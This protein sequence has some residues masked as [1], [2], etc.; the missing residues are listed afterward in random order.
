MLKKTTVFI[1][2]VA[3]LLPLLASCASL[4]TYVMYTGGERGTYYNLGRS[5]A[6]IFTENEDTSGKVD[7]SKFRANIKVLS[8]SGYRQNVEALSTGEAHLAIVRNDIAYF[9]QNGTGC[10]SEAVKGFS[11]IAY[12]YSEAVHIVARDNITSLAEL[13]DLRVAVG[14]KGSANEIIFGQILDACGAGDCEKV[15]MSLSASVEAYKN[16]EIDA[17]FT[18]TGLPSAT[19]K[20]LADTHKFALLSIEDSVIES[21]CE[22]YP[23]FSP[24]KVSKKNYSVLKEDMKTVCLYA[25]LLASDTLEKD[26]VYNMTKRIAE[27]TFLMYHDK[28]EELSPA[29][30][31]EDCCIV[32]HGGAEKYYKEYKKKQEKVTTE[33][34]TTA[35]P[36]ETGEPAGETTKAE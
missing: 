22:S 20:A 34:T 30:M 3:V 8:S 26:V 7:E 18:V 33:E 36:D 35:S 27:D 9:A 25:S 21:L 24:L 19:I 14:E 23:Y 15:N 16:E 4:P 11:A 5:I 6:G 1:I 12:L 29:T 10:Y 32:L 13:S 31:W 28:T 17:F 2:L